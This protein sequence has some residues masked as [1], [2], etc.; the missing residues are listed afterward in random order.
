FDN[1]VHEDIPTPGAPDD[2]LHFVDSQP[3]RQRLAGARKATG[4]RDAV[5]VAY[6]QIRGVPA[7]A[8]VQDFAFLGGSLS[9]AVGEGFVAAAEAALARET[10]FVCF[11]ASGGAR[12]QEGA[13]ALMQ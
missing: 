11:T 2:P 5:S 7:V 13:L 12:M 10:P 9:M 8:M 3:Y 1:G 4:E 6:G